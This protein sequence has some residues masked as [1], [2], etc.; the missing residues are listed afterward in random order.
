MGKKYRNIKAKWKTEDLKNAIKNVK[1]GLSVT[2]A[3][4]QYKLPRRT[5]GD[6]LKRVDRTLK[7]KRG[8]NAQKSGQRLALWYRIPGKSLLKIDG[9]RSH[10]D[11]SVLD[12]AESLGIQ[13]FCL[14]AHCSHELQ[15]LDE[16]FF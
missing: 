13:L 3:S 14:P 9:H 11:N 2:A 15:P 1:S 10:L 6:W 4:R 16:R 5:L 7:R 12:V 8:R